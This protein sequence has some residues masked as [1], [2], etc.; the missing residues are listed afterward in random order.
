MALLLLNGGPGNNDEVF[1]WLAVARDMRLPFYPWF[2]TWFPG[3][4]EA[5]SD[6]RMLEFAVE[7]GLED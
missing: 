3:L 1:R 4:R 7:T 5:R 2:I 6:P